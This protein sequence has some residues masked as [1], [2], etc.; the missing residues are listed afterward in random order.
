MQTCYLHHIHA[1]VNQVDD[2]HFDIIVYFD[3]I[4][5]SCCLF[6]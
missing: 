2:Y 6:G 3:R 4:L 5:A 1:H